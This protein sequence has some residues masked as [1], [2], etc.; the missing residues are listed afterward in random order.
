[1]KNRSDE[2]KT[3]TIGE[4]LRDAARTLGDAG[5]EN[6]RFEAE[7]LLGELLGCG[8]AM[9]YAH[10]DDPLDGAKGDAFASGIRRRADREPMAYITGHR[11]FMGLDL[12]VDRSVLIPRPDTEC[13]AEAGIAWLTQHP[14]AVDVLD[15]CTGSGAIGLSVKAA[16]PKVNVTLADLS[17][18]A[19][20]VAKRNA[21]AHA[22]T[23]NLARGDLFDAVGDGKFHAIISNPPYIPEADLATLD[24]DVRDYEPRMALAGG[25]SGYDFYDAIIAGAAAHLHEGGLLLFEAGDGQGETLCEKLR[26]AG[27]DICIRAR[28]LIGMLRG[29]GGVRI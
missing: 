4:A 20:A 27:F 26:A 3:T 2:H 24:R 22:L 15:L 7:V 18:E 16:L 13:V 10:G 21:A 12:M 8:R 25:A 6:P 1:M 14:E 29:V 5:L 19:L 17:A 28:D 23:V 11:E 9:L